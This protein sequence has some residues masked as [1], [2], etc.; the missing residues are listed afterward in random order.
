MKLDNFLYNLHFD[1]EK[2]RPSDWKINWED[3]PLAYK[4]YRNLPEFPL[5]SDVPLTLKRRKFYKEPDLDEVGHFLW[6]VYG[7]SQLSQLP[8]NWVWNKQAVNLIQLYRR[9]APSGGGLYP[10][11]LYIYLK[12]GHLPVGIYH[13]D[14]AHHRLLLLREGNFDSYLSRA[15]G[16]RCNISACFGTIFV[17]TVFWKNFFKYHNFSYRLQG[18]DAGVLIGQLLEVAKRFGFKS[19]VYFQFLDRAVNHLLGISDQEESVYTVIPLSVKPSNTWTT[20]QH[21]MDKSITASDLSREL[22]SIHP[23]KYERSRNKKE[24]PMPIKLNQA[25]M[26]ESTKL[27]R[28]IRGQ[29][30]ISCGMQSIVLPF[31]KRL[32][33]DLADVCRKRRSPGMNFVLDKVS[34]SQLVTLF[35]EATMSFQY[36]NDLDIDQEKPKSRVSLYGC[37]YNIEGVPDGAY[38]YDDD[39]HVLERIYPGDYRAFLQ[40]GMMANTVN[41]FEVPICL[42]VAGAEDYLKNELGY[43]GYRIQ[44][45]EA[46]MLV[47]R[48]LLTAFALEMGGHPL[49]DYGVDSC[50][51]L[52]NL[53]PKRETSLIQIPIGPYR[54]HVWLQGGLQRLIRD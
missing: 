24:Y 45:M 27:F 6:Y 37:F 18:L 53:A 22:P 2:I 26:L 25:S 7:L 32:S 23:E 19:V 17:T 43:R 29:P 44:Q 52:Y 16:N 34:F 47:Q 39:A 9:F 49:L 31:V 11:E 48:L 20:P 35:R 33:Y 30:H 50:D 38:T 4:L 12:V 51:N 21:A 42:H 46:G 28:Q 8:F 15:L 5:S 3:A 54:P 13:Y 40:S 10:S 41:L 36:K 14:V 1:A